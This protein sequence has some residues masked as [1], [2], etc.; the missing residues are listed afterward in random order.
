MDQHAGGRYRRHAAVVDRV[1]VD[2]WLPRVQG[3][4]HESKMV[5]SDIM[6]SCHYYLRAGGEHYNSIVPV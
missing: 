1:L 3:P 5:A 6:L 2:G 4:L